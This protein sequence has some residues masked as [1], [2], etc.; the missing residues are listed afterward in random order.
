[1][2]GM[3]ML[4]HNAIYSRPSPYISVNA[5]EDIL[6]NVDCKCV[7]VRPTF[8]YFVSVS[9]LNYKWTNIGNRFHS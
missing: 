6:N 5:V 9:H 4:S 1:M 2:F 8:C 3:S 7:Q